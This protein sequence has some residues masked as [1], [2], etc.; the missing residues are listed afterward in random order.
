MDTPTP[1]HPIVIDVP[2]MTGVDPVK[3]YY[4]AYNEAAGAPLSDHASPDVRLGAYLHVSSMLAL[5]HSPTFADPEEQGI[6]ER[7]EMRRM[8]DE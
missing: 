1:S 8:I 7:R 3:D 2:S 5:N 6:I 4:R